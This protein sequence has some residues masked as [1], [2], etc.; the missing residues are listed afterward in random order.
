M[1]PYQYKYANGLFAIVSKKMYDLM[2]KL[3]YLT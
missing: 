3:C 2:Y 1:D